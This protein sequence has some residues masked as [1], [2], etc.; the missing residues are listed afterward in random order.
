MK[1]GPLCV[2]P[3]RPRPPPPDPKRSPQVLIAPRR[4]SPKQSKA[5]PRRA[6]PYE[7]E[8]VGLRMCAR[9]IRGLVRPAVFDRP[10]SRSHG[11]SWGAPGVLRGRVPRPSRGHKPERSCRGRSLYASCSA[12]HATTD[13]GRCRGERGHACYADTPSPIAISRLHSRRAR[14]F[15]LCT[16]RIIIIAIIIIPIEVA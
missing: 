7:V 5:A 12:W 1:G 4:E 2:A 10:T 9:G 13:R 3:M 11:M 8:F 15:I 16:L 6:G 14:R